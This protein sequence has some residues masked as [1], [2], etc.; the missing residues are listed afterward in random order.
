[1]LIFNDEG[2][3]ASWAWVGGK[4]KTSVDGRGQS[5]PLSLLSG[6]VRQAPDEQ[7][8]DQHLGGLI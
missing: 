3:S 7:L 1:M 8:F 2:L 5:Q 6:E 4:G